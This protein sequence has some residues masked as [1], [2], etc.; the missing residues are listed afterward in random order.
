MSNASRAQVRILKETSWGVTPAAAMTNINVVSE[1]LGQKTTFKNSDIIRADTNRLSPARVGIEASGGITTELMYGGYDALIE[2]AM[3]SSFP[4]AVAISLTTISASSVDNSYN[5]TSGSFITDGVLVGQWIRVGGFATNA[6]NNGYSK[7]VSV[8]ALKVVVSGRVLVTESAGAT[9]TMKGSLIVNGTTDQSFSL[10]KEFQDISEFYSFT[11]MRVGSFGF[12]IA[13]NSLITGSFDFQGKQA[14]AAGAT[15]GTG[16]P[17]SAVANK[18]MNAVDNVT[19]L[20][21]GGSLTT[22]S[23]TKL[24][25]KVNPNLRAQQAV[26]NLANVGVGSGSI[27]V[28]GEFEVYFTSRT[29]LNKYLN[30][31][32]SSISFVTEEVASGAYAWDFPSITYTEGETVIPGIDQDVYCKM[33]FSA[34]YNTAL[35]GT[36][37]ITK[38]AP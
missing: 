19:T 5:R 21:E 1:S 35:A 7:V 12:D 36:L 18:S 17:N 3:R 8:A 11:G 24:S 26:G 23:V 32:G 33:K 13:P 31:T 14:T 20:F 6:V 30:N 28:D 15:I 34:F 10:E 9:V 27:A 25:F 4:T 22:L 37:G 2:G 16:A 38:M 29:Q